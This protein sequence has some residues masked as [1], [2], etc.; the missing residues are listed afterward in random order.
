[1][2]NSDY[3]EKEKELQ[4]ERK[5]LR[6]VMATIPNSL[7]ILDRGL[8]IKNANRSFYKLFQI[9]SGEVIGR[10]IADIL[11]DED[12]K[13]SA[14]LGGLL[15][16]KDTLENF[17][18]HYQS[19]KLGERIFNITARGIIVAEEEEEEEE[20]EELVVIHDVTDRKRAEEMLL[21]SEENFRH[22]L[23]DSPLGIRIV[24]DDG[25]ALYANRAIL[26]LYGYASI[27]EL[28]ATPVEKRYTPESYAEHQMR[29]EKR[30]RGDYVPSNYEV[31]IV[32]KDGEIRHLEVSRKEVLWN[33]HTRFQVLYNDVT[34][35]K[36]TVEKLRESEEK[37]HSLFTN[38]LNGCALCKMVFDG[39]NQPVDF[40]Y[41]EVNDAFEKL[42]G[43]RKE[44]VIGK[45]VTEAIPGIKATNPEIIT[46]YGEV[47]L[48][49]KPTAFEVFFK[50][51][52]MW[53]T[54][55]VYSPRKDYFVA[56]FDDITERKQAEETLKRSEERLKEAQALGRIGSWEFDIEKQTITWSEET[57]VLYER[58]L[59]L[60]TPSPEEEARYYS[61]E[62]AKVLRDYVARTIE[63][64]QTFSYDLEVML[65]SG[66]T[67]YYH[68]VMHPVKDPQGR[69][70]K[71]SGTVQDITERKRAEEALR[72]SEARYRALV[73]LGGEIGEAIVMLQDQG[74]REGVH[75][76]CNEAWHSVTGYCEEEL[77]KMSFFEL[78]HP[79]DREASLKRHR[80]K[81]IGESIPGLFEV[82]IIRKDGSEVPVEL[83]S[84][85]STH[86]EK[87]VNVAYIRDITE[88]KQMEEQIRA[89]LREKEVLLREIH[90]RVK[91]NL[92]VVSSLLS[93]QSDDITD[94][95]ALRLIQE[96]KQRVM[97]MA[98]VHDQLYKSAD[99]AR[100]DLG[101]YVQEMAQHLIRTYATVPD[102]ISLQVDTADVTLD[103]NTAI[104]CGLIINELVTN[105]LKHAFPGGRKG[106]ISITLRKQGDG[107]L[108]LTVSDNGVAFPE[109]LDFR[110]TSTLGMQLV[111]SLVG[112]LKGAIDMDRQ[113][114][115]KWE[116]RWTAS[117]ETAI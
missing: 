68:A 26:A 37:Y 81:L 48:T 71:L 87:P 50:P 7:L 21:R 33:G 14:K 65:P 56:V 38:M 69:V 30:Q 117:E 76:F 12:G 62:Q 116:I 102:A 97:A 107:Q 53:L 22:S 77:L 58:D 4:R 88:R 80:R 59:K 84:A 108:M 36:R 15:G 90:H 23:D 27:E 63:T 28:K 74:E 100:V 55:S 109:D 6:N 64:G 47:A 91:N 106:G 103:I 96:A 43:L 82:T 115:T 105:S 17:E 29:K 86:H 32:R 40:I 85:W 94:T 9:K 89:S 45:R 49:G 19:E 73:K 93:L 54:I 8:R 66:K 24:N 51:L 52:D 111:V 11:G 75:V 101:R 39:D 110:K 60:G 104:P 16:T 20:E 114:G 113:K 1:M 13:L 83:T 72:E 34:E 70:V 5:F 92:Q 95:G 3:I 18:L 2:D 25:E 61:P 10:K 78:V 44:D 42:T 31:S 67:A 79:K 41:V 35:R 98:L 57:Y 112:Q 46:I 99:L